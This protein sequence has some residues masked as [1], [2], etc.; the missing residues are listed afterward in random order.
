MYY[1]EKDRVNESLKS[2]HVLPGSKLIFFKNGE[3]QGEAFNDIY[4]GS[5]HPAMSIHKSATVSVNF[6]PNFK[7]PPSEKEFNYRG[8]SNS[9]IFKHSFNTL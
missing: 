2:L 5:Y 6:G 3:Y 4:A 8:V 7:F 9:V 1:E